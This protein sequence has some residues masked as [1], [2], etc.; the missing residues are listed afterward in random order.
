MAEIGYTLSSEEHAPLDLVRHAVL[1]EEAGF[2]FVSISDHYHP[3]IDRQGHSPFVWGVIGGIASATS[4][5]RLGTGVSC[6]TIRIHPAIIA[7]AAATAAC[8][9][10]GRFTLGL[11][12][13]EK[14]NEHITGARW[15][16][17][18]VRAEMLEEAVAVIRQLWKGGVQSH[19]GRYFTVENARVYDL[20]DP[21]PEIVVAAGGPRAGAMAARIG[22]GLWVTSPDADLVR[23]FDK[24]AGKGKP[25]YGQVSLCWATSEAAARATAHEW[26]PTS[27]IRGEASQELPS[28]AHFEQLAEMVSEDDVA[29]QVVCGPAVEPIL[30]RVQAYLDAGIDHVYLHQIGPDQ[31]GFIEF[32]RKDLLPALRKTRRA[33]A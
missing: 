32:A 2:D 33:A 10:P 29:A 13:G 14:L 12:S 4:R 11:G 28:P 30:E 5:I 18:E 24:A 3:W 27:A 20:P 8:L 17:W 23:Q 19:H 15:P 22:D 16:E 31:K 9:M 1:A 6:P 26:W 7:H 25:K 21:L